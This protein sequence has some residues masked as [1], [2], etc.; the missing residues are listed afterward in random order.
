MALLFSYGMLQR[1][2][3]QLATF[4]RRLAGDVDEL[5]G[6]VLSKVAI[7]DPD[8]VAETG[9][10]HYANAVFTGSADDRVSGAVFEVTEN[11]LA[12]SDDYEADASYIRKLEALASGRRAWV[13]RLASNDQ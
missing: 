4:G 9:M 12:G 1:A 10:T 6:F 7:D 13:Y 3:V 11:E 8:V 2:E 5:P